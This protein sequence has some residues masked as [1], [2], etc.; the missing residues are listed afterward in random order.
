MPYKYTLPS[1]F[2]TFEQISPENL[3]VRNGYD[4]ARWLYMQLYISL[5]YWAIT[6][7]QDHHATLLN[8]SSAPYF[9]VWVI[10]FLEWRWIP[11][12]PLPFQ[13]YFYLYLH[14][15]IHGLIVNGSLSLLF[16][17]LKCIRSECQTHCHVQFCLL[18]CVA[19]LPN[20]V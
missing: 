7:L 15:S 5:L 9:K 16:F 14:C 12:L 18:F 6:V 19:S 1:N 8:L 4:R 20:P 10:Q 11:L 17:L 2:W 13:E 3:L